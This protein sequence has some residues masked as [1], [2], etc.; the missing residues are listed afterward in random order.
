MPSLGPLEILVV[1]LVGVLVFPPHKL[2]EIARQV[3]RG[4]AELRR[5]QGSLS[6]E[7]DRAMTEADAEPPPTLPPK[8]LPSGSTATEETPSEDTMDPSGDPA[9]EPSDT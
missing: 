7:L 5:L 4:I 2:P 8:E 9:S 6:A 1:L 3:G